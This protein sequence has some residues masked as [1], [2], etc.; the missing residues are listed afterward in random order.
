INKESN[1]NKYVQEYLSD[2]LYH[3]IQL[4]VEIYKAV[5]QPKQY[6]RLPLKNINELMKLRHDIVHRNGKT[7]TT[8]EKIHTFNTATLNDAFKVVEE[9][10]N[11]MMNLISDAV[12]HHENEQI[13]RDL[14]DE[15]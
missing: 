5:L 1:A 4:V 7:K 6:P 12:E 14:E 2:I 3:R 10:L 15:F 9:F 11:N 13:A 8:D